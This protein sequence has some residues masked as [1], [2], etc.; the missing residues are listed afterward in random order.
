MPIIK[1]N[2]I[3][4]ETSSMSYKDPDYKVKSKS[5]TGLAPFFIENDDRFEINSLGMDNKSTLVF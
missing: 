5:Q 2:G 1:E 3:Y 4:S